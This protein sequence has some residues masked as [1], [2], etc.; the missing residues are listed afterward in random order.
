VKVLNLLLGK[1]KNNLSKQAICY[2]SDILNQIGTRVISVV[3][4]DS[5]TISQLVKL[6]IKLKTIKTS[7]IH[8]F[9]EN[10]KLKILIR[11]FAPDIII[12]Y[13]E[14]TY[15]R[16]KNLNK[17]VLIF[18]LNSALSKEI[19]CDAVLYSNIQ[20]WKLHKHRIRLKNNYSH[21]HFPVE[22]TFLYNNLRKTKAD[23]NLM[24]FGIKISQA[25]D[26]DI[27]SVLKAFSIVSQNTRDFKLIISNKKNTKNELPNLIRN[28]KLCDQVVIDTDNNFSQFLG[29]IDAYL[30]CPYQNVNMSELCKVI[31]NGVPA[32]IPNDN[33]IQDIVVH[34]INGLI[35]QKG[36]VDA[37]AAMIE[38]IIKYP[39]YIDE[40]ST[41]E[42]LNK[43]LNLAKNYM[44]NLI[45]ELTINNLEMV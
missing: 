20:Q 27:N 30:I 18:F 11:E 25:F 40:I 7:L 32:I 10:D 42:P 45:E 34:G 39:S 4:P 14:Y 44:Y 16:I 21:K 35:Y 31:N 5:S 12:A 43:R 28:Y 38:K 13:D 23:A 26:H 17:A 29:I 15:N 6:P 1:T 37:L 9:I 19:Q 22:N 36:H 24:T 33:S 3:H 2:Y 8:N 41:D